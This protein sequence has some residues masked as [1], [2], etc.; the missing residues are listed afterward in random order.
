MAQ[1]GLS[2]S[3]TSCSISERNSNRRPALGSTTKPCNRPAL[4]SAEARAPADGGGQGATAGDG[5]VEE[6]TVAAAQAALDA[7]Q[8]A[9]A[10]VG[11]CLMGGY[12]TSSPPSPGAQPRFRYR[13]AVT[14]RKDTTADTSEWRTYLAAAG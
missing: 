13:M 7:P 9:A 6:R 2:V 8:V 5:V 11:P 3:S 4:P 10:P 14:R 12:R 1:R